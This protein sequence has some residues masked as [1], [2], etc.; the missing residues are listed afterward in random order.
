MTRPLIAALLLG[1]ALAPA[2]PARA[3]EGVR[4]LSHACALAGCLP[5]DAPGYPITIDVPG[6]YVLT[7]DLTPPA[8]TDG[9]VL[10]ASDVSLDFRGHWL[11]GPYTCGFVGCSPGTGRGIARASAA[12]GLRSAVRDGGI[13]GFGDDGVELGS[14]S[15]V[16][17]MTL[18]RLG[19]DG[20]VLLGALS[21]AAENTVNSIGGTAL[22][23]AGSALYRENTIAVLGPSVSGG[24]PSGPNSCNDG[25]CGASGR[26][27]FYL[28]PATANGAGADAQCA[29][30]FHV[31]ALSELDRP[32]SLEYDTD[33]GHTLADSGEGP[34]AL[35]GWVSRPGLD[36]S[37]W[38]SSASNVGGGFA[39]PGYGEI[40]YVGILCTGVTR[41][42]GWDPSGA[43]CNNVQRTWCVQ[44]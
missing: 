13:S 5:N 7:S 42:I 26:K 36:C 18:H 30:G 10:A 19:G 9:I 12:A 1:V 29:S 17:G 11:R 41:L 4:E 22:V 40:P 14:S 21:F 23:L 39:T 6:S 38:S 34:P 37:G 25:R 24:R 35:P 32:G 8:A 44:D 16:E 33:R 15:R 28:S 27:L 20:I 43:T 3:A 2:S 31:A